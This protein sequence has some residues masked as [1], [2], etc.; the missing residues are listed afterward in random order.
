MIGPY[1]DVFR[2]WPSQPSSGNLSRKL[3]HSC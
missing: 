1:S 3:K 2:R